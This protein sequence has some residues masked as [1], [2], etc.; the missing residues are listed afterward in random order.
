MLEAPIK[1]NL[2]ALHCRIPKATPPETS[3]A[4]AEV[5]A[6]PQGGSEPACWEREPPF[7]GLASSVPDPVGRALSLRG[8]EADL[9]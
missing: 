7:V 6:R 3:D 9:R 5:S 8:G 1:T 2:A 4:T